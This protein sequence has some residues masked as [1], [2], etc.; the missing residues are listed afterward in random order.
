[1]NLTKSQH[2][3]LRQREGGG[4]ECPTCGN[5]FSVVA[6]TEDPV[7]NPCIEG[8]KMEVRLVGVEDL[9]KAF[10][11]ANQAAREGLGQKLIVPRRVKFSKAFTPSDVFNELGEHVVADEYTLVEAGL[12]CPDRNE[13]FDLYQRYNPDTG[14]QEFLRK[15]KD[16]HEIV[17]VGPQGLE[18]EMKRA[19]E[20]AA[21]YGV[22]HTSFGMVGQSGAGAGLTIKNYIV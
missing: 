11:S 8:P 5:I 17:D 7:W 2:K 22:A 3:G 16:R 4:T 21:I 18:A 10:V 12:G 1:M 9:R 6:D 19:A 15:Y 20:Q 13:R 14:G